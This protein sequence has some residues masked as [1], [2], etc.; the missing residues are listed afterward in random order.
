MAK[1]IRTSYKVILKKYKKIGKGT[2]R[3]TQSS[4]LLMQNLDATK[5]TYKF[6]VLLTDN[7]VAPLPEEIRLNQ[8]DEFIAYDVAYYL[9]ADKQPVDGTNPPVVGAVVSKIFLPYAPDELSRDFAQMEDAWLG[10][11]QILVNKISRLENWDLKKHNFIPFTQFQNSSAGIPSATQPNIDFS[12]N[13]TI[14]MQ[15]ML[16]L[17]GAKKNDII[18]SLV[19]AVSAT[20]TGD[21]LVVNGTIRLTIKRMALFFRGMLAQNASSFQK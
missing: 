15:P 13:G 18:I 20:S 17:S 7:A 5:D 1:L 9:V 12:E 11:L 10:T 14:P 4:L 3:L 8:N 19:H 6:P 16:V 2:V 21:W